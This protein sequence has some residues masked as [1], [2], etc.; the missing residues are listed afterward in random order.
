VVVAAAIEVHRTLGGP[1]L[2]ECVYE[3][4]LVRELQLRDVEVERQRR[5]PLEY[6]GARLAGDLRLDL[7][8]GG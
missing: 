2:L 4:A 5:I 8:V 1:G 6:K 7:L 3:E